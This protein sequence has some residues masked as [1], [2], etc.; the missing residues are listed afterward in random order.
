MIDKKRLILFLVFAFSLAWITALV[1]YLTGGLRASPVVLPELNLSLAFVLLATVYMWSPAI[2]NVLTRIL[3]R[4][5]WQSVYIK[6][7]LKRTWRYWASAWLVTPLL[8]LLGAIIYFVLFSHH[9][10]PSLTILRQQLTA[11][12]ASVTGSSIL[13]LVLFQIAFAIAIAPIVNGFSTFGEEFG[14]RAYLLQKLLPL[15]ERKAL[16]VHGIIWGV[17]H[18]PVIAMGHNYGFG[19]IGAPWLGLLAMVW[20]TILVGVF[21]GW[22][23]LRAESV[24]PAVIGHGALNGFAAISV[25]AIRGNP[26]PLL[27]PLPVGV[28]G[29]LPFLFFAVWALTRGQK[30]LPAEALSE[31][32]H[33]SE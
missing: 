5:G 2:A 21:F 24:W 19:Y 26:S 32:L 8:I 27:G 18:W 11:D 29:S 12:G 10:D 33:Q 7:N 9:F 17:W 14:W 23:A 25:Y 16:L 13:S 30:K 1:I 4:E 20:F 31:N 15:G 22:L 6:P 3:T 28:V